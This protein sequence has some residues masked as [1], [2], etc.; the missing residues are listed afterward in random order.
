MQK[1]L[2][3][4]GLFLITGISYAQEEKLVKA[5]KALEDGYYERALKMTDDAIEHELTKKNP[6][7]YYLNARALFEL[8]KDEV[9]ARKNPDVFKEACRMI[10]KAKQKDKTKK[11]EGVYDEFIAEVVEAN[12]KIAFEEYS[13]N[14]YLKAIKFYNISYSLNGDI[15]AFYM[16]G[17]SYQLAGDTANAKSY[18][19]ILIGLYTDEATKE[20]YASK[21]EVDAFLFMTE[22]YWKKKNYDSANYYLEMA[23]SVL[24]EKNSKINFIQYLVAKDQIMKQPPS[25]LIMEIIRKGLKYNPADTFFIKK[26]NAVALYLIRNSI[27]GP[28]PFEAD[29]MIARFARE[30]ALKGN[31]PSYQSLKAV[32]IFLQPFPENVMW[33]MSD[34]Y[35]INLH[36]KAAAYLAK[37]YIL[38]TSVSNDTIMPTEKDIVA[39][40]VKIINFAKENES[41]GFVTLL[42]TQAEMDY[43]KSKEILELKKKL[44]TK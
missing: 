13:V 40:W 3:L 34:Y 19:K 38:K 8:S 43:P 9:Y 39:R 27:D 36:D 22:T 23:R 6:L 32:D 29:S 20:K 41:P 30:K 25:S 14:K 7:S 15:N 44:L 18:Y 31:D 26:E 1:I 21:I 12:N 37:K 33:K 2:I 42:M 28:S 5:E 16:I 10:I 35:Y 11:Y 17:K 24:G 4:I